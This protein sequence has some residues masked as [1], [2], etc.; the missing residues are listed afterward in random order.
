MDFLAKLNN[1]KDWGTLFLRIFIGLIF[2][3]Y[4]AQKLFGA[5]G[6]AGVQGFTEM[7]GNMGFPLAVF[8]AIL[9]GLVE[10]LGGLALAVGF[11]TRYAAVLLGVVMLVA[12]IVVFP[13]GFTTW[14]VPFI[15]LWVMVSMLF[16]G[17]GRYSLDRRFLIR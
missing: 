4:G 8:F 13:N 3:F 2:A 7:L 16:S 1:Y 12:F 5:F 6:G 17:A 9:V 10:F 14:R 11:V 15:L